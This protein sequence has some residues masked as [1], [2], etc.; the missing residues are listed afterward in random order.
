MPHINRFFWDLLS[1]QKHVGLKEK[2]DEDLAEREVPNKDHRSRLEREERIENLEKRRGDPLI[3]GVTVLRFLVRRPDE[4]RGIS[5]AGSDEEGANSVDGG[6]S[7]GEGGGE[8][9]RE[10]EIGKNDSQH[11]QLSDGAGLEGTR[12]GAY[13]KRNIIACCQ[14]RKEKKKETGRSGVRRR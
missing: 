5:T 6:R 4:T 10:G 1:P 3:F 14:R 7:T 8:N 9:A 11:Q 12:D 13:G 2:R